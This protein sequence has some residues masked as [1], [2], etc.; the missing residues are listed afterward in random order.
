MGRPARVCARSADISGRPTVQDFSTCV[1]VPPRCACL[2]R[3]LKQGQEDLISIDYAIRSLCPN[4]CPECTSVLFRKLQVLCLM[5][6]ASCRMANIKERR[7]ERSA[8]PMSFYTALSLPF[9]TRVPVVLCFYAMLIALATPAVGQ[10]QVLLGDT[11]IEG[12]VDRSPSGIAKAFP[13]RAAT[14]GQV[15]SASVY[16]D[17][18]NRAPTMW[19]GMY[20]NRN[21]HPQTLMSQAVISNPSAGQWNSVKLPPV[22]VT[23][24]TTYWL[25]LL[26][27]NG[28][29]GFRDL[30]GRCRSEVG[31]QVNL[32]TLP[33]TWTTGFRW[34]TC[35]VSMFGSGT[36]T[37]GGPTSNP[38]VTVSP[39]ATSLLTGQQQQF[40]AL[41]SGFSNVLFTWTAS[42]GTVNNAGLYTAPSTAG[43]YTV[44]AKAAFPQTSASP[45]VE[46]SDSAVVTVTQPAPPPPPTV[47]GVSVSPTA[48]SLPTGGK[49]QFSATVAGAPNSGVNWSADGGTIS[50]N[51][52]YTAPS[53]AG[54]YTITAVSVL[55]AKKSGSALVVVS[56][57]QQVTISISP[58]NTS[59]S[60]ADRVQFT[61]TVAGLSNK[62]VVWSVTQGTGT[63]TQSG[64]FTAPSKAEADTVTATSQSDVTKSAMASITVLPAHSVSLFWDA[65]KSTGVAFYRI[66]RGATRGGPYILLGSNITTTTFKDSA[67]QAG[68]T[69]FY[70]TTTVDANN[71]ESL[72][73]NE[74]S[75]V[76]PSP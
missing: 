47:T 52:S 5:E 49:Q 73:S 9:R 46:T 34:P 26:G 36:V 66:Y 45:A 76:I 20:A 60:Q 72:F 1:G 18:S 24:G 3:S 32:R 61:A 57:P 75:S 38:T 7:S 27:V 53:A 63:I 74:L 48:S 12:T 30:Y 13:F 31:R 11:K 33:A 22:Q 39:H 62:S 67:V 40:S 43:T 44:T 10:S 15:N 41:V 35:A 50:S 14:T 54:T 68:V 25:A 19:V 70:V 2:R 4:E 23:R 69:Y 37:V 71:Q 55:D 59:V 56:A 21:G 6:P 64:L 8:L 51:G 42:G 17:S 16:L 29:V 28:Q 58:A 65:S